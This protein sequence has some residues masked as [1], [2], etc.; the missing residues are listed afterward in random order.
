MGRTPEPKPPSSGKIAVALMSDTVGLDA[1]TER[2]VVETAKRLDK[3]RF[4]V[5]VIC[6][7]DS[8]QLRGVPS[9][10]QV[11]VFPTRS[12]NSSEGLKQVG[13]SAST[14]RRT[15]WTFFTGT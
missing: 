14:R 15:A 2:Q 5:H 12:V 7:E 9:P 1:G 11:A 10:C 6:L 8:P 3:E 4:E 13:R